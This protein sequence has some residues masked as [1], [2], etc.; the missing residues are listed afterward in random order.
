[1]PNLS[2]LEAINLRR[3]HNGPFDPRPISL[4]HQQ[5]LIKVAERAPSHFNSQPWRFV[6]IDDPGIRERIADIG[7]RTMTQLISEGTFFRRYRKYFRFTREE[8]EEKRDGIYIDQMPA[9]L[10]PFI[11]QV[12][13]DAVQKILASLGV[14]KLLGE[15]NRKLIASSPLLLAV[16]LSKEE[17]KPSELSGFYCTLS[18]GMAIEHIWLT[19][20]ELGMG[21][22]FVSTPMEVP[23]AWQEIK[24]ILQV[25]DHLELMAVYR[26]GYVPQDAKR[27][28]IDWTSSQRKPISQLAFRNTC[29]TP[30]SDVAAE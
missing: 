10:R 21:I 3:T 11:K 27:P 5:L 23:D 16:L 4:H 20:A 26:L 24:E 29:L 7:G 15:D 8:M 30:E 28:R 2:L 12:F 13:S 1:M 17:Y 14:P 22:Q 9:P 6:L 25:P 18:M 19:C